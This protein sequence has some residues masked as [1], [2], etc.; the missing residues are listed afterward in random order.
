MN[1]LAQLHLCRFFQT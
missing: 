1:I